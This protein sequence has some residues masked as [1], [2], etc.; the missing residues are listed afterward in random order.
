[1]GGIC[2]FLCKDSRYSLWLDG[3]VFLRLGCKVAC[4]KES[5]VRLWL[6]FFHLPSSSSMITLRLY[7]LF[8]F[9]SLQRCVW[10]RILSEAV[11]LP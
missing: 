8:S 9:I 4:H 7:V 5:R 3:S 6:V 11:G 10:K 2:G 1:M